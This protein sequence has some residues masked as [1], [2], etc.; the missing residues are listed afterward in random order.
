MAT[1]IRHQL[2]A[3]VTSAI[4]LGCS[5]TVPTSGSLQ[6]NPT[7]SSAP[8]RA[9]GY[10]TPAADLDAIDF[11]A[12]THINYA[13][14]IPRANGTTRPFSAPNH[15][16]RLVSLA[17]AHGVRVLIAVGGWGWDSQFETL[18][19]DPNLRAALAK[20]VAAFC[21]SFDL[22]GVDVD[23]EY[24][25]AGTSADHFTALISA[26]RTALPSSSIVTAAV[27]ADATR[28]DGVTSD[29]I[30]HLDFVNLMAYDGPSSDHASYAMAESAI[31]SWRSRGIAP[32]KIVL[33]V[34]FYS[35]PGGITYRTLLASD[36]TAAA[37]DRVYYQ[38]VEQ[39]Y[40]GPETIR[41]KV[42]LAR[43]RAGGVMIWE[44]SQDARG[45]DSL[46][47]VIHAAIAVP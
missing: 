46:L 42:A 14:L 26:L 6:S 32:E 5:T 8:F 23:W 41:R 16:R 9:V 19:A 2:F 29:A 15:L 1:A 13:F 3:L 21:G 33:G 4:L 27:L 17:H 45:G 30:E 11:S 40:N 22:D 18:A 37:S 24:P 36:P 28:A 12:L 34:P 35:R 7:G 44:L 20:R 31:Q 47:R 10:V 38:G 25:D 43:S 39:N